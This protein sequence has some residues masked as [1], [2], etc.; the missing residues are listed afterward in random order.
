MVNP[1]VVESINLWQQF[2][3]TKTIW[4]WVIFISTIAVSFSQVLT[5][6]D[7]IHSNYTS[8]HRHILNRHF[9]NIKPICST[10]PGEFQPSMKF[11]FCCI[12]MFQR[13]C[14][15]NS[16]SFL[17]KTYFIVFVLFHLFDSCNW[18]LSRPSTIAFPI[19]FEYFPTYSYPQVQEQ[20][21]FMW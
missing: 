14:H 15:F 5:Q 3:V 19:V 10:T 18:F 17:W 8:L 6:P 12:N 9:N 13:S 16:G 4:L 7:M 1:T 2:D 20:L 21:F 11:F